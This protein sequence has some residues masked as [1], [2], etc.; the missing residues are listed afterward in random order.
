[1]SVDAWGNHT[2]N[3]AAR[4]VFE[5]HEALM[6][7]LTLGSLAEKCSLT[8]ASAEVFSLYDEEEKLNGGG[9]GVQCRCLG[10]YGWV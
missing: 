7:K 8:G 10:A 5:R 3:D 6:R 2:F 9:N 4:D 1:M